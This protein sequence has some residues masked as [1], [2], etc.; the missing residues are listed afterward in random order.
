[1]DI[2]KLYELV[3]S[4]IDMTRERLDEYNSEDGSN[5]DERGDPLC[6][7]I[8][9]SSKALGY[10]ECLEDIKKLLDGVAEENFVLIFNPYQD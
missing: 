7:D 6:A 8:E 4:G 10:L 1:M 3:E 2:K 9:Q 5:T